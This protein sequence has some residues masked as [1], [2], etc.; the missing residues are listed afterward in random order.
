MTW[1]AA[2]LLPLLLAPAVTPHGDELRLVGAVDVPAAF[3]KEPM[4]WLAFGLAIGDSLIWPGAQM[5]GLRFPHSAKTG[6]EYRIMRANGESQLIGTLVDR[7]RPQCGVV[8]P[9]ESVFLPA[10]AVVGRARDDGRQA[11]MV[12]VRYPGTFSTDSLVRIGIGQIRR[13]GGSTR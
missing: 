6:Y 2:T 13:A 10:A 7:R 8:V 11:V 12:Y 9:D 3:S 4:Q 5:I 1:L